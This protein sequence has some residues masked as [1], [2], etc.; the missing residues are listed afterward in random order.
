MNI[1]PRRNLENPI[2]NIQI[3][4]KWKGETKEKRKKK[5]IISYIDFN[6]S[7]GLDN[8]G[9]HHCSRQVDVL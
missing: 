8:I 2:C 1:D 6:N 4:Y 9:E 3:Q 5:Y 7:M